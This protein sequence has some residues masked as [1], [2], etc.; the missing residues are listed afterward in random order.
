MGV[1]MMTKLIL[2]AVGALVLA[3]AN[4]ASV[5]L[6][7]SQGA[8]AT[9]DSASAL[10]TIEQVHGSHRTCRGGWVWRWR[11]A[12]LHRHVGASHIPVPC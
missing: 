4:T 11:T 7:L 6:P 12:A 8:E 1:G 5:A 3:F 10:S 2:P 9:I